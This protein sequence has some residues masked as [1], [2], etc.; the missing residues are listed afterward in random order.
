MEFRFYTLL[1]SVA[2]LIL[3]AVGLAFLYYRILV[4]TP[5][6]TLVYLVACALV[7]GFAA[8]YFVKGNKLS[9]KKFLLLTFGIII[10]STTITHTVATLVTPRWSFSISTDKSTYR[11]GEN[12]TITACLENIGFIAHSFESRWSD[13]ITVAACPQGRDAIWYSP[14]HVENTHFSIGPNQILKK[15]FIW[16]QTDTYHPEREI[17]LGQYRIAA[18]IRD[19]ND[20]TLFS[21]NTYINITST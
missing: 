12:V 4:L 10:I 17:R 6:L 1:F 20:N 8:D 21:A 16:N 7:F 9:G 3:T 15:T 14:H 2:V 18:W 13:P 19:T 5:L 11:L